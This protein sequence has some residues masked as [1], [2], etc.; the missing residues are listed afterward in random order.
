MFST[1]Y[2]N[3]NKGPYSW[4]SCQDEVNGILGTEFVE[5]FYRPKNT[6]P[7][8]K[9][10]SP[11]KNDG[12]GIG[13]DF[14]W[15]TFVTFQVRV[16]KLLGVGLSHNFS[17][18][19]FSMVFV[20]QAPGCCFCVENIIEKNQVTGDRLFWGF[21]VMKF[22]PV[23]ALHIFCFMQTVMTGQTNS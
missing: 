17:S 21:V 14:L 13:S 15:G 12:T 7:K 3:P 19:E 10:K 1:T 11:L 20:D 18:V 4:T 8:F 6:F 9:Q 16:V 2:C 22:S 23:V 5:I